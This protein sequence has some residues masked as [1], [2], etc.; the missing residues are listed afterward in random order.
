LP[1]QQISVFWGLISG[2][3]MQMR[4]WALHERLCVM[5]HMHSGMDD[6]I[7]MQI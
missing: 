2:V 6:I 7:H 5:C 4:L 1:S 3:Y